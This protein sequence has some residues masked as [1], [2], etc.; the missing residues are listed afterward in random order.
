MI[1]IVVVSETMHFNQ[2]KKKLLKV[3]MVDQ[4]SRIKSL[5]PLSSQFSSFQKEVIWLLAQKHK[6]A[7]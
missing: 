1:L 6:T 7:C 3:V 4:V 2:K 5:G